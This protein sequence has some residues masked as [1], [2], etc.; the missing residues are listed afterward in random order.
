MKNKFTP[1]KKTFEDIE[2]NWDK[3]LK[4]SIR[5]K[6]KSYR[7]ISFEI[8]KL[9]KKGAHSTEELQLFVKILNT[10]KAANPL[11]NRI[12][13]EWLELTGHSE[14]KVLSK[15]NGV[16]TVESGTIIIF[17]RQNTEKLRRQLNATA[18]FSEKNL[19]SLMNTGDIYIFRTDGDGLFNVQI[20][21]IDAGDTALGLSAKELKCV[22]NATETYCLNV[23]SGK[24]IV[25]DL[26][27][28]NGF[29]GGVS[30]DVEPGFYQLTVF[31]FNIPKR[32]L[33]FIFYMVLC[34]IETPV[35][36][37]LDSICDLMQ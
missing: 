2:S 13:A 9:Y 11:K 17:D 5:D 18:D 35:E 26:S 10:T 1:P 21:V 27:A 29:E 3:I 6:M 12:Y 33:D 23:P 36:N 28:V 14:A 7:Q 22:S 4:L 32:P 31:V 25:S 30:Q 37:H 24:L 15:K 8:K 20:R 34:K 19:I 16:V